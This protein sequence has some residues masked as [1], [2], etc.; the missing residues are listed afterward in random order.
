MSLPFFL[1]L[2]N[3]FFG[4]IFL[5][6]SSAALEINSFGV[7]ES[8]NLELDLRLIHFQKKISQLLSNKEVSLF[9]LSSLHVFF[10]RRINFFF[11][12]LVSLA[13]DRIMREK[14]ILVGEKIRAENG[15]RVAINFITDHG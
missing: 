13:T 3:L 6:A 7:L 14:A 11:N 12:F 9:L 5:F 10:L 1:S 15:V 8:K 4:L 2:L